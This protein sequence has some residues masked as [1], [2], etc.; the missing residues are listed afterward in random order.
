MR[1]FSLLLALCCLAPGQQPTPEKAEVIIDGRLLWSLS[2]PRAGESAAS[3]ARDTSATLI[4]VASDFRQ[5][6]EDLREVHLESESILLIGRSYLFSVTEEDARG[7]GRGRRELFASRK[8]AAVEAIKHYRD[9][10]GW[11]QLGIAAATAFGIL[12]GAYLSLLLIH[13]GYRRTA[14]WLQSLLLFRK[15]PAQFSGLIRIFQQPLAMFLRSTVFL[16]FLALGMIVILLALS[17]ALGQFPATAGA[18]SIALK[19]ARGVLSSVGLAVLNYLPNFLVLLVVALLTWFLIRI[20]KAVAR[21][22][23]EGHLHMDG[24]H[25]EWALPTLALVRVLLILFGIVVAFP[26][27]PGGDSPALRG[28]SLFV[29]VLVS[30]GSGS[31]MGNVISGVIL[32][33]MRPFQIGDRVRISDAVGDVLEKSLFVTRLRTIKNEEIIVPNSSILGAQII[34][35]S[36]EAAERGLILHT[37][38]TIGYD[39]PWPRVHE[40]LVE[41]ALA[42]PGILSDPRPFVL[43]TSLNDFHIS[44]QINAY[45]REPNRMAEILSDLHIQ[46]Q[47]SFRQGGVEIMSPSWLALRDGNHSTIPQARSTAPRSGH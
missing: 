38:V 36:I 44:Y 37:T 47:D 10:R 7:Q 15:H 32:T 40:L 16:I 18:Y 4:A 22:I 39:T 6:L 26:Y 41:A 19:S 24:F 2:C 31:A 11:K 45:T 29:G 14:A 43:Q 27:L 35:Y 3:R 8:Q 46:I 20:S 21:A 28:V 23:D 12:M 25:R 34:N 30:F 42:T 13:R 5:N 9:A 1:V 33:Y 17:S